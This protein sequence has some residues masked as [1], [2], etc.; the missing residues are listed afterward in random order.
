MKKTLMGM[1]GV[2]ILLSSGVAMAD[3]VTFLMSDLLVEGRTY[4][5]VGNPTN[6]LSF[7]GGAV[8]QPLGVNTYHNPDGVIDSYDVGRI[9]SIRNDDAGSFLY[10]ILT[11]PN[12]LTFVI[13]GSDDVQYNPNVGTTTA[14]LFSLGMHVDVFSD[15]PPD[16]DPNNG[17]GAGDGTLVLS[18]DAHDQWLPGTT[19]LYD[20]EETY[21]YG[22]GEFGGT[23]LLDVVGGAWMSMYDTNTIAAPYGANGDLWA[24]LSLSFSLSPGANIGNFTLTGTANGVGDVVPEPATMLLFGTGLMGLAGIKRRKQRK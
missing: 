21:N 9:F 17:A 10:N 6:V 14:Q 18:L 24:D 3:H 19:D 11:D 1:A 12:E 20:L 23:A 13:T 8:P 4:D 16:F 22:T 7:D 2:A 15:L 5:A